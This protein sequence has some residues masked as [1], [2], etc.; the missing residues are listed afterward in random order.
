MASPDEKCEVVWDRNDSTVDLVPHF[1]QDLRRANVRRALKRI[2]VHVVL[3][4]NS[5]GTIIERARITTLQYLRRIISTMASFISQ[6]MEPGGGVVLLPFVRVVIICLLCLT[7][8]AAIANVARLH[9][10]ILSVL[11]FGLLLSLQF[12]EAELNRAR[13]GSSSV[14]TTSTTTQYSSSRTQS[15]NKTD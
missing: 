2:P 10:I 14:T 11:S 13:S 3:H 4:N 8:G 12:F 1:S 15:S 5:N 6:I 9:M 7:V